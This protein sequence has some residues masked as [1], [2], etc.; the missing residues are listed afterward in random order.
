MP[1]PWL[2]TTRLI[3]RPFSLSD[4]PVVK[5]LAGD[6]DIADTTMNISHPYED[7]VA[8]ERIEG[9]QP[10]YKVGKAVTFAVAL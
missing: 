2:E 5:R 8:E 6:R 7:G 4:A 1:Q 9:H 10:E 3:L